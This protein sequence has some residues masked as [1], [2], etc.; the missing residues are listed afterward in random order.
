[1]NSAQALL[2]NI[3]KNQPGFYAYLRKQ[4]GFRSLPLGA[5]PTPTAPAAA[6]P[7]S[8]ALQY[9]GQAATAYYG[10]RQQNQLL[11][12]NLKLAQQGKPLID[13]SSVAPTF[14]VDV[15]NPLL[16]EVK[17]YLPFLF[18]GGAVAL[19]YIVYKTS[20]RR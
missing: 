18:I 5:V 4:K 17:N 1:M 10:A 20:K 9:V 2:L 12:T 14:R 3:R 7:I 11:K 6:N 8:D 13:P 19:G 15:D 16:R